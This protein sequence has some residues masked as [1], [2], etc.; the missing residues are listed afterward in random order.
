M[1]HFAR[2]KNKLFP[3]LFAAARDAH[4]NGWPVMRPMF[5]EFPDDPGCRHLDRQYM[6]GSA[7]LVAPVF[8]H[9]GVVEYYLPRGRWTDVLSNRVIEG[10]TWQRE[11]VDF[12]HVP[13]FARENSIISTSANEERP[14]WSLSE[15][16]TL[17][18][19]ATTDG[20]DFLTRAAASEGGGVA[21]FRFRRTGARLSIEQISESVSNRA[22]R[23]SVRLRANRSAGKITNGRL[24]RELPEGLLVEWADAS[25]PI[26]IM[27][28]P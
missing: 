26:C 17:N 24:S 6:L 19:F 18:V 25:S 16:L 5:I 21:A 1:R 22:T 20:A 8:R 12:M 9:D 11:S 28:D 3:Y 7:L 15:P 10:G 13:L 2:L 4:E 27:L 23:M 14:S